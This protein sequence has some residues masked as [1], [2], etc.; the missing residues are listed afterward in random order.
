MKTSETKPY[1]EELRTDEIDET[2]QTE[3]DLASTQFAPTQLASTQ[4]AQTQLASNLIAL[5][6]T[7]EKKTQRSSAKARRSSSI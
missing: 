7:T 1:L 4:F 5:I 3:Y 6:L 2:Q